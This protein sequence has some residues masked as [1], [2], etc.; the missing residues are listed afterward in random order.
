MQIELQ[1]PVYHAL[2]V[3]SVCAGIA[4]LYAR[5]T[6]SVHERDEHVLLS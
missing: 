1:A 3:A 6:A 4:V 2:A 5:I